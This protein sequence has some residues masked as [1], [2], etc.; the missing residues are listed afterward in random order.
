V[1]AEILDEFPVVQ[2]KENIWAVFGHLVE[3]IAKIAFPP[4]QAFPPAG[5]TYAQTVRIFFWKWG[6]RGFF[7]RKG[8][9]SLRTS[10]GGSTLTEA[11]LIL[12][13]APPEE[14]SGKWNV[15]IVDDEDPVRDLIAY[16]LES[17]GYRVF[18]ARNAREALYLHAG[19][20]GIFHLLLTD[21]CMQPHED[22]FVLARAIR[23]AR[24]DVRVIY[25]S[26]YVEPDRLQREV[27]STGA[28]FLPKPFTPAALLDCVQRSLPAG[29]PA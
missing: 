10:S 14:D 13:N 9:V 18:S 2:E 24:P 8:L 4:R 3:M 19:F 7:R 16:V 29:S 26:G 28:L 21:I 5:S 1:V 22:G 15:L 12:S 11:S 27:D 23:R 20:P 25:S 17:H 6:N